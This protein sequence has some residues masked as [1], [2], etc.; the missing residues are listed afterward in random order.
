LTAQGKQSKDFPRELITYWDWQTLSTPPI[1]GGM[2]DQPAGLRSRAKFYDSIW[3]TIKLKQ[4]Y[5]TH[6]EFDK[7]APDN[8]KHTMNKVIIPARQRMIRERMNNA[9]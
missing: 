7:H 1:F 2:N 4:R 3:Q 8:L 9:I 6:R 5:K